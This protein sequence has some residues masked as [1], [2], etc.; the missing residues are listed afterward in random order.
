MI[1]W[2]SSFFRLWLLRTVFLWG[3]LGLLL[4]VSAA[5][6]NEREIERTI[7][8]TVLEGDRELKIFLPD[9][10]HK[11]NKY[12][13]V[14]YVLDSDF[15]FEPAVVISK[16]RASRDLMP[17]AI[18]VGVSTPNSDTRLS[19]ALPV[20][21]DKDGPLLYENSS[22]EKFLN[23]MR[24]ELIPYVQSQYRVADYKGLIGMSPTVGPV[25][26]GYFNGD[27]L[28]QAWGGIAAG[29]QMFTQNNESIVD[30]VIQ[31][32][33]KLKG[34]RNWLYLSRGEI[35]VLG[36]ENLSDPTQTLQ[37]SINKPGSQAKMDV[38]QGG[39]H[40]ASA[41]ASFDNA[42]SFF[43]PSE[44]WTPDYLT[45]REGNDPLA[46]LKSFYAELSQKYGFEAYPV[47]DGYWMGFSLAG[48]ARYL[49]RNDRIEEAIEIL[50]WGQ[51]YSP[52]SKSLN[53]MLQELQLDNSD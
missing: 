42:F 22:P 47:N 41:I 23:F 32:S 37:K 4:F 45:I 26:Q 7:T 40:Y 30:K 48:T 39:E 44:D 19:I 38:I 51:E 18:I 13:P 28:F 8:S 50:K 2:L 21:R 12:Y 6:A 36:N 24:D 27:D 29:V 52:N 10:Y 3:S 16:I 11:S 15:L 5:V 33:T 46:E 9:S 17:E 14:F 1:N 20:R 34:T 31:T 43:F 35:D 49:R 53:E 25:F